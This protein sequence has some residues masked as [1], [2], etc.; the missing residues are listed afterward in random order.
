MARG[1]ERDLNLEYHCLVTIGPPQNR[2]SDIES[3]EML[4]GI[5]KRTR[6]HIQDL[7]LRVSTF[8]TTETLRC[9]IKALH[10]H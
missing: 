9:T 7:L 4:A 3:L 1:L 2:L 6:L 8:T 5:F 10:S